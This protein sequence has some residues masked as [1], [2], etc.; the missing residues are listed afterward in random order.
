MCIICIFYLFYIFKYIFYILNHSET[1]MFVRLFA[2]IME[3]MCI[4]I[5]IIIRIFDCLPRE[6]E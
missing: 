6:I 3:L 4:I 1:Q 2:F 5:I